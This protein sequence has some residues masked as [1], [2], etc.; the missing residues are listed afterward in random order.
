MRPGR[1]QV[2]DTALSAM[3]ATQRPVGR[4]TEME[5]NNYLVPCGALGIRTCG[6]EGTLSLL[7]GACPENPGRS[8]KEALSYRQRGAGGRRLLCGWGPCELHA[9]DVG[10]EGSWRENS[11][12]VVFLWTQIPRLH[13]FLQ[14]PVPSHCSRSWG[15]EQLQHPG[16]GPAPA[17]RAS[18]KSPERPEA[19]LSAPLPL[20]CLRNCLLPLRCESLIDR[21]E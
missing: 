14:P 5:G 19:P 12:P 9:G 15:L 16:D 3:R 21:S 4:K 20:P 17:R 6:R 10:G 18:V 1:C 13:V 7:W 8:E 2:T 11:T